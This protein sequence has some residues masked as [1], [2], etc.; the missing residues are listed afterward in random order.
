MTPP[1]AQTPPGASER[2]LVMGLLK[3]AWLAHACYAITELG[4]PDLLA[5]RVRP[6]SELAADAGA[7]AGFLYRVLRALTTVDLVA[8]SAG[9]RFALTSAGSL[10]RSDL[11]GSLLPVVAMI[12][13]EVTGL[14]G[15]L[16]E[17][18]RTGEPA[19]ERI[20]GKPFY[21]YLEAD[22]GRNRSM[23]SGLAA[24]RRVPALLGSCRF[25]GAGTVADIG[26]GNG[27]LLARVLRDHP[28]LRGV[29]LELPEPVRHARAL[30]AE[31][32]VAD[33]CEVLEGDF[34]AA[35]P[36]ADVYVLSRIVRNW[37][38]E[39]A[40]DLLT[41]IRRSAD[42]GARLLLF[43]KVIPDEP[44]FH[45]AKI[46]D[47]LMLVLVRGRD[48]TEAEHRAL[49]SAA[50]FRVEQIRTAVADLEADAVIE[51]VAG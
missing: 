29:L 37:D 1:I 13:D 48:R 47:L 8:E 7:D 40:L 26:G 16:T 46:D 3:G 5:D 25:D 30:L 44:V 42:P 35:V 51:A 41:R 33:R 34:F 43:E 18:L 9:R 32:G 22:P 45:P 23:T 28:G 36:A 15:E 11:D 20:N 17:S 39:H 2:L 24:S 49:L 10:L 14:F 19:F 27:A 6:V 12:R 4:I 21:E 38:D 50:G 31:E